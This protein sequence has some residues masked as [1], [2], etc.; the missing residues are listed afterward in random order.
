MTFSSLQVL[1]ARRAGLKTLLLPLKNKRDYDADVPASVKADVEFVFVERVEEALEVAF[2]GKVKLRARAA[3][4]EGTR[5]G[6]EWVE[7]RL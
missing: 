4:M 7:S 2:G 1:A 3:E 6:K 5:G